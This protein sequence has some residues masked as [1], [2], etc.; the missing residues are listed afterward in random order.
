LGHEKVFSQTLAGGSRPPAG[1]A[2]ATG[3]TALGSSRS[4]SRQWA[5]GQSFCVGHTGSGSPPSSTNHRTFGPRP[6]SR[7]PYPVRGG[8]GWCAPRRLCSLFAVAVT[9]LG[10]RVCMKAGGELP[11]G[12]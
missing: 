11:G 7:I 2:Q 6:F 4:H 8:K 3:R 5:C 9:T 12:S 1:A 10:L